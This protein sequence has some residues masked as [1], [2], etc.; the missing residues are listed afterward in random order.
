MLVKRTKWNRDLPK[1]IYLYF[2]SNPVL[3]NIQKVSRT[4]FSE[5]LIIPIVLGHQQAVA[6]LGADNI[7][8]ACESVYVTI[9]VNITS[10]GVTF[11]AEIVGLGY[12]KQ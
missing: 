10:F 2:L 7:G 3:S 8:V 1:G 5:F 11:R 6:L 4:A 9:N 12:L